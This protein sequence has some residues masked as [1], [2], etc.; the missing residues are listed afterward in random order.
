[1]KMKNI[2]KA[3]IASMIFLSMGLNS[4]FA[5]DKKND[6]Q[7]AIKDMVETQQYIFKAQLASPMTGQQRTLTSDYDLTV[8]KSAVTSYLPYFGRAYAAPIDPSQ[9]GIK[10][11]STKFQYIKED[12]KKDGWDITIIPKD[13]S[14]VQKL[15]LH[16]SSNGYATLQVT[17][18]NRQPISF[19]GR[20]EE[21]KQS[22]KAF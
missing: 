16:I 4:I 3:A 8:S 19:N 2:S 21:N 22:K 13:A 10:F 18:I 11:T 7:T 6:K 9:G 15:Y 14:D 12:S 17:S 5:Q 20:I 1:M